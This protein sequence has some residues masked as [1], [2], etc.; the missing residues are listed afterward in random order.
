MSNEFIC[1]TCGYSPEELC[2]QIAEL[3]AKLAELNKEP[4]NCSQLENGMSL[5]VIQKSRILELEAK[6]AEKE[7]EAELYKQ[8]EKK[9]IHIY[10]DEF[11]EKD[12]ELKE[13]RY[14]VG[15][16]TQDKISFAVK[17]LEEVK[18]FALELFKKFCQS[19]EYHSNKSLVGR[20]F[21]EYYP[22]NDFIDNQIKILREGK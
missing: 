3:E 12:K 18:E 9:A 15:K 7:K 19:T 16:A 21:I 6:L 2:K 13:L 1:K 4:L 8:A 5:C 11:V 22:F 10:S 17:K 20:R 14:K